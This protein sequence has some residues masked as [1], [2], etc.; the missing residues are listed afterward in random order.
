[1]KAVKMTDLQD[2]LHELFWQ[3]QL[4]VFKTKS[5][6]MRW[7]PMMTILA[8]LIQSKSKAAY[9]TL[10]KTGGL[11]ATGNIY[12]AGVCQCYTAKTGVPT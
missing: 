10:R 9:E 2:P 5:H 4:K 8:I 7:H 3:E 12:P 1:M 6:G 11:E